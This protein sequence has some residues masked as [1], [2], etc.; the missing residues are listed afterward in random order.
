MNSKIKN[1]LLGFKDLCL[2]LVFFYLL[3]WL[4]LFILGEKHIISD[5]YG[6]L[7]AL[8]GIPFLVTIIL[9]FYSFCIYKKRGKYYVLGLFLPSFLLSVFFLLILMGMML[10]GEMY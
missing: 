2:F 1:I 6:L 9:F 8:F 3:V 4:P 7:V 10:S 5:D